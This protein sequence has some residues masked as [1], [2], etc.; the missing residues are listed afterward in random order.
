MDMVETMGAVPMSRP[1][2]TQQVTES[3]TFRSLVARRWAVI[4][5]LLGL[6]FAAYYG[7]ILLVAWDRALMATRIGAVT[8]LAIPIG[9]GVIVVAWV[10]T[11]AYV[12]WANR[13]Y[14]PEVDRLKK[15]LDSH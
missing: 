2:R 14:D 1:E 4:A 5:V 3:L 7:F 10:L 8:T 9:V 11:A 13:Y 12:I 6:L 15:Q